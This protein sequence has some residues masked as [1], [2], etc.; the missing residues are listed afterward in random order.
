M[1]FTR[2]VVGCFIPNKEQK[3]EINNITKL[4]GLGLHESSYWLGHRLPD[5]WRIHY[6]LH[7]EIYAICKQ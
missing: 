1:A 5:W 3:A 4:R 6:G 2:T 7:R